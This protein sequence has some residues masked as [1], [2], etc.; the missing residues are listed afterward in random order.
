MWAAGQQPE[1]A[2]GSP[3]WLGSTWW[4]TGDTGIDLAALFDGGRDDVEADDD[5][6]AER[7]TPRVP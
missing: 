6:A 3:E 4:D 1:A 2:S 7:E 5:R